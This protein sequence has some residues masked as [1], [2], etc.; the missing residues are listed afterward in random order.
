MAHDA[1]DDLTR[2]WQ[3]LWRNAG[4]TPAP[5]LLTRLMAAYSEPHRHYHTLQH[6]CEC[7]AH[8]QIMAHVPD[9]PDEV[10]LALWFHDA[11][12]ESGHQDNEA[13]SAE[14]ARQALL[15]AG[16]PETRANRVADLIMTTCHNAIPAGIDAKVLVDID[17]G[18][19]GASPIRFDEYERQ[20]REEYSHLPESVF[21]MG[22]LQVLQH[23]LDR[24]RLYS[25]TEFFE[26]Y[27]GQ[28]RENLA[29]SIRA[30]Q[31]K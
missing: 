27:E 9:H 25:T 30:L 14:W 8:L 26:K 31:G 29:R 4:G 22:R 6:L 18:I 1:H 23:F 17:L 11:I 19:L 3:A 5:D 15:D 2:H 21:R 28:A 16:L 10:G 24:P 7:L 12:L 13:R 20:V